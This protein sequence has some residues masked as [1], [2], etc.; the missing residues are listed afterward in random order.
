[1]V[2]DSNMHW[3]PETLFTD[4][5]LLAE[6]MAI[7]PKS[8]QLY[9]QVVPIPGTDRKQLTIEQP[10]GYTNLNYTELDVNAEKRIE[11]MDM[12]GIDVGILRIPCLEEWS[13]LDMCRKFNNMM[14]ETVEKSNG[15]LRAL[16]IVP[17]WGTKECIYELERC[18]KDLGCVGVEMAAHYGSL[19]MDEEPFRAHLKKV[20]ELDV[21]IV[22]HHT[23]LPAAYENIYQNDQMRRLL[24]RCFAQLTCLMRNVYNGVFEDVPDLKIIHSYMAGGWFAFSEFNEVSAIEYDE[25][26]NVPIPPEFNEG[27]TRS[28]ERYSHEQL[29]EWFKNN[30]YYDMCH[31]VPWGKKTL[32]FAIETLG[33][34]HVLFASSYPVNPPWLFGS[35]K[36]VEQLD[37]S[38][39]DKELVLGGNAARLFKIDK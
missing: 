25:P 7:P 27:L 28:H 23:P 29:K 18:I 2:I 1:M 26:F 8:E 3:M 19:H 34:D 13:D 17:P 15:R 20:A 10:K 24:G 39:E 36:F 6:V 4:E 14:H 21:P 5:E 22:V 12:I 38:D 37:I 32:E 11:A 9:T 30:I 16:A 31:P 35:V 33:A